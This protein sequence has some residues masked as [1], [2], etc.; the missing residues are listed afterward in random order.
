MYR[1]GILDQSLV[2]HTTA[3]GN[4]PFGRRPAGQVPA[5]PFP[6]ARCHAPCFSSAALPL[7]SGQRQR[8]IM[9]SF[10]LSDVVGSPTRPAL[11]AVSWAGHMR[12][13][14]KHYGSDLMS[15]H[16]RNDVA[17]SDV[18][19]AL[20]ASAAERLMTVSELAV[21]LRYSP[22][23]VRSQVRAGEI[24]CIKFNSRAW[25][26]HWPTVLAALKNL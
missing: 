1:T 8:Q 14:L 13:R 6:L 3:P 7:R 16:V 17:V 19:H 12:L 2:H 25:R 23:W 26:F 22:G 5:A 11:P 21:R 4:S 10:G 18:T 24:P 20:G 9:D 15:T